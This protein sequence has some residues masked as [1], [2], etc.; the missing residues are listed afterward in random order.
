MSVFGGG[1]GGA[2]GGAGGGGGGGGPARAERKRDA[3]DNRRPT[4]CLVKCQIQRY[5]ANK[6]LYETEQR[7][8]LRALTRQQLHGQR[9]R[10]R[11]GPRGGAVAAAVAVVGAGKVVS[12]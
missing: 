9:R 5:I 7:R 4:T 12:G 2:R 8:A 10:P 3:A 1:C 6:R 11:L